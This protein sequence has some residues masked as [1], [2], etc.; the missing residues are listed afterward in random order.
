[1]V[2]P[3]RVEQ[4]QQLSDEE[5]QIEVSAGDRSRFGAGLAHILV[6][7]LE[8]RKSE[9]RVQEHNELLDATRDGNRIAKDALKE[10]KIANS[11]AN[12]ARIWSGLAILVSII[13]A[14]LVSIGAL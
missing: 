11:N 8:R 13:V 9:S 2:D 3:K 5:L 10:A 4:V 6:A 14:V 12:K 1:M 7:E